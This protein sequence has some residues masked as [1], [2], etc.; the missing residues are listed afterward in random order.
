[1][2]QELNDLNQESILD[3]YTLCELPVLVLLYASVVLT[4][5]PLLNVMIRYQI[6]HL[7][8]FPIKFLNLVYGHN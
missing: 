3:L 2:L 7:G 1:M 5:T 6:K 4:A 8:Y